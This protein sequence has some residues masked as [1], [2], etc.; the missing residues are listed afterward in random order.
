MDD[1][2]LEG[3]AALI[4]QVLHGIADL[5]GDL[6]RVEVENVLLDTRR[7]KEALHRDPGGVKVAHDLEDAL[8][9]VADGLGRHLQRSDLVQI[10][11]LDAADG[12][13]RRVE[14]RLDATQLL[15][16]LRLLFRHLDLLLAELGLQV[17]DLAPLLDGALHGLLDHLHRLV[18]L[19]LLLREQRALLVGRL[20]HA[21]HLLLRLRELGEAAAQVLHPI[22]DLLAL[23]HEDLAPHA[24]E[25]HVHARGRVGV[26]TLGR[27]HLKALVQLNHLLEHEGL[28]CAREH[29]LFNRTHRGRCERLHRRL[30]PRAH[31]KHRAA[32]VQRR[33]GLAAHEESFVRRVHEQRHVQELLHAVHEEVVERPMLVARFGHL[34]L[35]RGEHRLELLR[36]EEAGH[37]ARREERVDALD[38]RLISQLM[39]LE[40]QHARGALHSHLWQHRLELRL[41]AL[42]GVVTPCHRC[43]HLEAVHVAHEGEGGAPAHATRAHEEQVAARLR[44]HAV[45]PS[46]GVEGFGEE[47][48]AELLHLA[49]VL[50]QALLHNLLKVGRWRLLERERPVGHRAR[51]VGEAAKE[52]REDRLAALLDGKVKV[53]P[54]RRGDDRVEARGGAAVDEPVAQHARALEG[55]RIEQRLRRLRKLVPQEPTHP[56][57]QVAR[58][59]Q[60]VPLLVD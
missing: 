2:V 26:V 22:R 40:Q 49:L 34:F 25:R 8:E 27:R 59:E 45:H 24:R 10:V 48:K 44:E 28:L 42:E 54:Q 53:L 43:E 60:V 4:E 29:L 23:R 41:E 51:A 21:R 31:P 7:A 35:E 5:R 12:L 47:D 37:F 20:R 46:D 58:C 16:H 17:L 18:R 33:V 30:R 52:R 3:V 36:L 6:A 9:H 55:P 13:L 14:H 50:L 39:V 19:L 38:E 1:G 15:L 56:L 11:L 57:R 32:R